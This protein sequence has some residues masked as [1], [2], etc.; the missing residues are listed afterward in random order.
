M[1]ELVVENLVLSARIDNSLDLDEV[2]NAFEDVSYEPEKLPA[3]VF[4]YHNPSRVVFITTTGNMVCTGSKTEKDAINALNETI[5]ALKEKEIIKEKTELS[6]TLES[7]V[8]SKNLNV[9]LPLDS[10]QTQLPSDQCTYQPSIHPWLEYRK[11]TYSML[12]FS[13]GNIICTGKISLDESKD[14]FRK[15]EDT[16]TSI[17]CK[18]AE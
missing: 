5:D 3:V 1:A 9:S 18:V 4:Y 10:I 7:L 13:S 16:L 14:A 6:P 15:I 2:D 17:G 11:S 12:L 8:V